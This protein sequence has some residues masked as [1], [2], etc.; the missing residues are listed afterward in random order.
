MSGMKVNWSTRKYD[1]KGINCMYFK[2]WLL[3]PF[4]VAWI[5]IKLR[6]LLWCIVVTSTDTWSSTNYTTAVFLAYVNHDIA[7]VTNHT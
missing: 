5:H 2:S 7:Y 4:G 3:K 6:C 1:S